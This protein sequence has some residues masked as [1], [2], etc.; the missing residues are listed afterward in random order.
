MLSM[1]G[2][3]FS[4]QH[5]EIFFLFFPVNRLWHFKQIVSLGDNLHGMSKPIFLEKQEIFFIS[6]LSADVAQKV[7]KVKV[8]LKLQKLL[9]F[10]QQ[11]LSMYLPYFKTEILMSP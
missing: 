3:N 1:L 7:V 6:L 5:F 4:R 2:K 10:F 8:S 9:T 11:K